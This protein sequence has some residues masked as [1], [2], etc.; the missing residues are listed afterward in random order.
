MTSKLSKDVKT[1]LD[2]QDSDRYDE[3]KVKALIHARI[4]IREA[5]RKGYR[6]VD[7]NGLLAKID[8][9]EADIKLGNSYKPN[10]DCESCNE[11]LFKSIKKMI[12]EAC[13]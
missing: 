4:N 2:Y 8:M 6:L 13:E 5:L 10:H 3:E 9:Y 11:E 7:L 1:W 12:Q